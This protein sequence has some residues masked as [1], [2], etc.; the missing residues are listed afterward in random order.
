MNA[1]LR[2][3]GK[4]Q[5]EWGIEIKRTE[6]GELDMI[7]TLEEIEKSLDGLDI[8]ERAQAIQKTFGDEGAKG[9]VPL[10][11]KLSELQTAFKDVSEGSKG[12]VDQEV[13]KFLSS[14]QGQLNALKG[15]LTV[16]A[17]TIGRVMLPGINAI[18]TP[19]G[20]VATLIADL[21]EK[22]PF[23][24]KLIVGTTAALIGLRV[25][26]IAGGYAWT[27]VKGGALGLMTAYNTLKALLV[28]M[29]VK[30]IAL[31]VAQKAATAAQWL[32]NT[33]LSANPIGLIVVGIGSLIAAGVA[34]CKNW[35]KIKEKWNGLKKAIGFGSSAEEQK[36][37]A[38][39]AWNVFSS[40][41]GHAAGT[42]TRFP[43]LAMVAEEGGESIIPHS[44]HRRKRAIDL[45]QKT[46][47]ILGVNESGDAIYLTFAPNINLSSNG[48]MG[49]DL[50]KA[51]K[52]AADDLM[53]RLESV[54]RDERRL[55][56]S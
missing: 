18:A 41:P 16:L 52:K 25:T 22:F 35:D 47:E 5:K 14:A 26:A 31:A 54:R 27:F 24:T 17:A 32:F 44:P 36:Q 15:T 40:V 33:A 4:A 6:K 45:W 43:H 23:L 49:I 19:L 30:T 38:D 12:I 55:S 20:K 56:F 2:Q 50:E 53:N 28:S 29:K 11:N 39:L 7:A 10:L 51:L 37:E 21:A 42:I 3:L 13:Q 48:D 34:L 8:D 9:L 1:V 46:G